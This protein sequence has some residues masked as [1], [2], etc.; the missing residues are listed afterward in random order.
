MNQMMANISLD[1]E[2]VLLDA[3]ASS[4]RYALGEEEIEC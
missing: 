1:V 4:A 2:Y 3:F